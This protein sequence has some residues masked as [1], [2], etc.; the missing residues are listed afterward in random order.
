ML[1]LAYSMPPIVAIHATKYVLYTLG[2]VNFFLS[3]AMI[4]VWVKGICLRDV[5]WQRAEQTWGKEYIYGVYL[6]DRP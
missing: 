2:K 4:E 3:S 5:E 6:P 1:A